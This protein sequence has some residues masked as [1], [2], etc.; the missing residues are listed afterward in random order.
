MLWQRGLAVAY[1]WHNYGKP[2]IGARADVENVDIPSL[3]AFYRRYYQPDD[4]TLIVSGLFDPAQVLQWT[5]A[6]FGRLPKPARKLPA[7]YTL[8]PA[9]NGER[10]YAVR[11]TDGVPLLLATYHVPAAASPDYAAVEAIAQILVDQPSGRLHKRLVQQGKAAGVWGWAWDLADPGVA[12]F[13]L[14]LA[15]GQDVEAARAGAAVDGRVAG[16][17]ADHRRGTRPRPHRLAQPVEP[18][19]HQLRGHRRGAV[20]CRRRRATGGCSSCSATASAT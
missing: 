16:C 5:E 14:Q 18:A 4:A 15:P 8:D 12:M 13:G 11:R 17:R 3:Q 6:A 7:L 20:G 9:Q 2:T 10:D 19:L 1:D